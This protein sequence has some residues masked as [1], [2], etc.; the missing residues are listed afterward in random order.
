MRLP[1]PLSYGGLA[2]RLIALALDASRDGSRQGSPR[3]RG[4]ESH[5][6]RSAMPSVWKRSATSP[7]ELT[8]TL[9]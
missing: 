8:V 9:G 5:A 6:L 1:P 7:G 4:F 3:P 2:E